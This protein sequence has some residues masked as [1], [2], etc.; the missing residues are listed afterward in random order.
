MRSP[1]VEKKQNLQISKLL[2]AYE[3]AKTSL[4][5]LKAE[6][7]GL[8]EGICAGLPRFPNYWARDTGWSLRGYL[9]VG[10]YRFARSIIENF[11][12]HQA[13]APSLVSFR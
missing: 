12:K 7:D 2:R 8:G 11:F 5:Y 10:D 13:K 6:Y 9:A 1:P 3:K 4:Q